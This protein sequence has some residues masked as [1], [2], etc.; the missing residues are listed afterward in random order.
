MLLPKNTTAQ[1][2]NVIV[3]FTCEC[4][5]FFSWEFLKVLFIIVYVCNCKFY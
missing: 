1:T 4:K 3:C 5:L 2:V